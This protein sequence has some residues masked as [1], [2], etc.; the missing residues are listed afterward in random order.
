[1]LTVSIRR[2]IAIKKCQDDQEFDV[3]QSEVVGNL[4]ASTATI[5][6][7][8]ASS[9]VSIRDSVPPD[10]ALRYDPALLPN[11]KKRRKR[12]SGVQTNGALSPAFIS[13]KR[14]RL[15][16]LDLD[17]PIP[18]SESDLGGSQA[19]HSAVTIPDSQQNT[20]RPGFIRGE[21]PATVS[22]PPYPAL[23]HSIEKGPT[24]QTRHKPATASKSSAQSVVAPGS[25]SRLVAPASAPT[26]SKSTSYHIERATERGTSVSTAAT[27]PLSADQQFPPHNRST[28]TAQSR[29]SGPLSSMRSNGQPG[30]NQRNNQTAYDVDE[31]ESDSASSSAILDKTKAL[32]KTKKSPLNGRP[33]HEKANEFN[34]PPPGYRRNSYLGDQ[35][36]TPELPPTPSS[37]QR[38]EKQQRHDGAE[39]YRNA[40]AEA[41]KQRFRDVSEQKKREAEEA[42][43]VEQ[44]KIAELARLKKEEQERVAADKRAAVAATAARLE[45]ERVEKMKS[46]RKADEDRLA[47]KKLAEEERLK[48][49]KEQVEGL[50]KEKNAGI[51]KQKKSE[52]KMRREKAKAEAEAKVERL[53]KGQEQKRKAEA[54]AAE[55]S[56]NAMEQVLAEKTPTQKRKL[57]SAS[58]ESSKSGSRAGLSPAPRPQSSTP[59]IPSGKKS[60]L[61]S[62]QAILPSSSA[63][64]EPPSDVSMTSSQITPTGGQRR[65][66]FNHEVTRIMLSVEDQDSTNL[67]K[68]KQTPIKPPIKDQKP[69]KLQEVP[70]EKQTYTRILPPGNN[71][72]KAIS[73]TPILPPKKSTSSITPP[74]SIM[75]KVI[76]K[77]ASPIPTPPSKNSESQASSAAKGT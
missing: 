43:K 23:L 26:K 17:M 57:S 1:M 9:T 7:I 19:G 71:F 40:A 14:Q 6:V 18:S 58:L 15:S 27:S 37:K 70:P 39:K 60:A 2:P 53:R 75:P 59:F 12:G 69:S 55:E 62:S 30:P 73:T 31:I 42:R 56:R 47:K 21:I 16:D 4:F 28:L 64:R 63:P 66:S 36:S 48:K 38:E 68:A 41:A 25:P 51:E 44:A 35:T 34:T 72:S 65:V 45:K 46:E 5:R 10:S 67:R 54:A 29:L 8:Q 22:P 32:L 33:Q 50:E 13:N 74:T 77:S 52:D 20:G 24:N 49:A 76:V 61:K 11:S 3:T